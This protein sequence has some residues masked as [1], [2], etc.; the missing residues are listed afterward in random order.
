MKSYNHILQI[1]SHACAEMHKKELYDDPALEV[2]KFSLVGN[3]GKYLGIVKGVVNRDDCEGTEFIDHQGHRH[4]HVYVQME[5][6]VEFSSNEAI[7]NVIDK[8]IIL[9]NG[10][11]C[12]F[13]LGTCFDTTYDYTF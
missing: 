11:K 4:K 12:S 13:T 10:I 3:K 6:K 5:I 8:N 2:V 1:S 9:A 7:L